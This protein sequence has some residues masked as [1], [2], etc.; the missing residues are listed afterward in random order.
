MAGYFDLQRGTD[1]LLRAQPACGRPSQLPLRYREVRPFAV[2]YVGVRIRDDAYLIPARVYRSLF[3]LDLALCR[4]PLTLVQR[5]RG[6]RFFGQLA[7]EKKGFFNETF[8][9]CAVIGGVLCREFWLYDFLIGDN[10]F[11]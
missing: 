5:G 4:A 6:D 11:D 10:Y 8:I 7:D 3:Q 2:A 9:F 1:I